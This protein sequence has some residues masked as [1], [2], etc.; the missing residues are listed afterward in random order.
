MPR[1]VVVIMLSTMPVVVMVSTM[2]M[3][4]PIRSGW[5]K[6]ERILA[7]LAEMKA[8]EKPIMT[9]AANIMP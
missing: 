3:T 4:T 7:P 2:P 5:K 6:L 9:M 1:E 8:A